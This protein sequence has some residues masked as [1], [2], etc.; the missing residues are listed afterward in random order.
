[1][2]KLFPVI[3]LGASLII[4]LSSCD[5]IKNR[6]KKLQRLPLEGN[7]YW[8]VK[9]MQI[10]G[11]ESEIKG[12][13]VVSQ[14]DIYDTIQ[15]FQWVAND[16]YGQSTFEWQ[17]QDKAEVIQLNHRLYCA[18]CDGNDLDSL[19]FL[20]SEL[21]GTYEVEKQSR[22]KMIFKSSAT[23]GFSGQEVIIEIEGKKK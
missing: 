12:S 8:S 5:K 22:K 23:S 9:S 11:V 4:A 20:A 19:D 18:E 14:S 6:S 2:R 3:L 10:N 16:S 1:M 21:T 7:M 15:T 13:W 17:F